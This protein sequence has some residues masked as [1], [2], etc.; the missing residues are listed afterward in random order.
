MRKEIVMRNIFI[1]NATQVV[2]SEAHPEGVYS[3]FPDY[4]KTY[5]SRAYPVEGDPDGDADKALAAAKADYYGRLSAIYVGSTARVMA[6][7]VLATADGRQMLR[8]SIGAF[9]ELTQA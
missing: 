3:A 2:I 9:P 6:T 1:V 7:V 5:D 8:E 4:P